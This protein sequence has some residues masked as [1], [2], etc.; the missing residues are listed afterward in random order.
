MKMGLRGE[1]GR[2]FMISLISGFF[3]VKVTNGLFNFHF[4]SSKNTFEF[5]QRKLWTLWKVKVFLFLFLLVLLW[6]DFCWIQLCRRRKK[7]K[8]NHMKMLFLR[9]NVFLWKWIIFFK[10]LYTLFCTLRKREMCACIK[11]TN[12]VNF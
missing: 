4:C 8:Y 11:I 2:S 12:T 10:N 3:F 1:W 7:T 6:H 9:R 5:S